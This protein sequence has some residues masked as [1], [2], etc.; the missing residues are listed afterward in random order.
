[1]TRPDDEPVPR[2]EPVLLVLE[3]DPAVNDALLFLLS[4]FGHR[5]RGFHHPDTLLEAAAAEPDWVGCLVIDLR[6]PERSGLEVVEL[7][8]ASHPH[9]T[10]VMIS[11]HGQV[12][13]AVRSMR[14][15]CIDFLEKPFDDR[16]LC[17]RVQQGLDVA[18]QRAHADREAADVADRCASLSPRERQVMEHVVRGDKN[19]QIA[20]ALDITVKTVEA[21]RKHVMLKMRAPTLADL[22][23]LHLRLGDG[24]TSSKTAFFTGS[25]TPAAGRSSTA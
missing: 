14:V 19:S 5:V 21:H 4:T 11:G 15:G 8:Q 20:R 6:L 1:M 25:D 3:D 24:Q 2:P 17:R 7:L 12:D 22:V 16:T 13:E 10:A 9:L 23:R 18:V